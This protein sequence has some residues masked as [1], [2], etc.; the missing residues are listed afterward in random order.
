MGKDL[1]EEDLGGRRRG[2]HPRHGSQRGAAQ[3]ATTFNDNP[4]DASSNI[5]INR[6][7]VSRT[8]GH[9][10]LVRTNF[11]D[12]GRRLNAV[13]YF[14]D[15]KRRNVGP[16]YGAVIYRGKDGDGIK[17]VDVYQM[18]SFKER[19]AHDVTCRWR[20]KWFYN[21]RGPGYFNAKFPLG[22]F[23]GNGA[24]LRARAREGV[25][26]HSLP[27]RGPAPSWGLRLLRQHGAAEGLVAR[28]LT[29]PAHRSSRVPP[30]QVGRGVC[31]TSARTSPAKW[32]VSPRQNG[33]GDVRSPSYR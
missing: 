2:D 13:E 20:Y 32:L 31:V 9:A 8:T 28:G 19:G 21:G 25:E 12:L 15:T 16:E 29:R 4:N 22:C 5:D 11:S 3:A 30:H 1:H 23:E 17:R 33:R 10:V 14:F 18:K 27:R 24:A 7:T 26:L 6:V